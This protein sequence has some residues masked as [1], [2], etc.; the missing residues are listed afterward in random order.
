[1]RALLWSARGRAAIAAFRQTR[2]AGYLGEAGRCARRL[3]R[4]GAPFCESE[5]IYLRAAIAYGQGDPARAIALL[6]ECDRVGDRA[7]LVLNQLGV[8]RALGLLIGGDQG[9]ALIQQLL[10]F[11]GAQGLRRPERLTAVFAPGFEDVY[12][13][14]RAL[15]P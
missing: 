8:R 2:D 4:E 6:H 9:A 3:A 12:T 15:N 13:P 14:T 1:M 5:A 7:G 11:G 10:S